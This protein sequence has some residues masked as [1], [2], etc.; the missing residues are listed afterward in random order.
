[1]ATIWPTTA[2]VRKIAAIKLEA[3]LADD[4]IT[5][6]LPMRN[7]NGTFMQWEVEDNN[8]GLQQV[9]G[10]NGPPARVNKLGSKTYVEK[11]GVYGEFI[12]IDETEMT[13]LQRAAGTV[14]ERVTIDQLTDKYTT[15][16][17]Q[18]EVRRYRYIAWTLV[19]T[20]AYSVT[21]PTG[22]VLHS[23]SY[24]ITV[25]SSPTAWTLANRASAT[26]LYDIAAQITNGPAAGT[27]FAAGAEL[28]MNDATFRLMMLN[29]NA[30][31]LGGRRLTGLQPA[32][33][34]AALNEVL[35]A[36]GLPNIVVYD[37]WY[38]NDSDAITRCIPDGRAILV[39]QRLDG[40]TLGEYMM[41]D[42]A[43]N[44]GGAPGP[45]AFINDT[46]GKQVPPTIEFHRGHNGGPVLFFPG[47]I[48]VLDV[49]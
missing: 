9:R 31:D 44:P 7:F 39:G 42:N 2:S 25:D 21:G 12:Q 48:R 29:T 26:P 35:A 23:G 32:N 4:P 46:R 5:R 47:S 10:L 17:A 19:T 28:W 37:G 49:T 40:A 38:N 3:M 27:N 15:Q 20:G 36:D 1:M 18:R 24:S 13:L 11:P 6:I 41:T 34:R 33:G 14:N 22:Q 43:N 30:N 16:L 45:Y 8:Y